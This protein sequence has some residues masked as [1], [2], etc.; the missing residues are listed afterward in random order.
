MQMPGRKYSQSSLSYRYGFNGKELDNEVVQYDYGFRIY[1]PR[2]VRFKSVDPLQ[3]KFPELTPY[4]F[5]S[6]SPV[7]NVDLDGRESQYYTT[8]ITFTNYHQC[9]GNGDLLTGSKHEITGDIVP[10]K[11]GLFPNGSL[12]SGTMYT[13]QTLVVDIYK[14]ANGNVE[15]IQYSKPIITKQFYKLSESDE[16]K[17]DI[18]KRPMF[19]GKY[20]IMVFGS[21][22]DN[23]ESPGERPNP[24]AITEFFDM[25]AW[26]E[27]M[28]PV[29]IGMDVK[30]PKE[31]EAPS[32]EDIINDKISQLK[33]K[34]ERAENRKEKDQGDPKTGYCESCHTPFYYN[35]D[36]S[37]S[38]D[39]S[40]NTPIDTTV[41]HETQAD[42]K[43]IPKHEQK[44][45]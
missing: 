10:L 8:T 28:E 45:K 13:I 37:L 12:G 20:Q 11:T 1:D 26:N 39:T 16:M 2:L 35:P 29:L 33:D 23:S 25:K 44:S 4:Q 43:T 27:I 30:S 38:R 34:S 36:G 31:Y 15:E 21:G 14:A 3:K 7:A 22:S 42:R 5:A 18:S 6:N 24:N 32:L 19:K 41:N 17:R 40:H 9:T